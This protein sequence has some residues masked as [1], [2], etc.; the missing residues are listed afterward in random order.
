MSWISSGSSVHVDLVRVTPPS[1]IF[2]L[3]FEGFTRGSSRYFDIEGGEGT[4]P[5]E[6]A[7]FE[8]AVDGAFDTSPFQPPCP[9]GWF[10]A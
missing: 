4:M 8:R 10:G 2:V 7:R 9:A 6:V 1:Q 3:T 5:A